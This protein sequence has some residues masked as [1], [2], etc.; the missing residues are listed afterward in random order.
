MPSSRLQR[1]TLV[2]L[3]GA[4]FAPAPLWARTGMPDLG[5]AAF[6]ARPAPLLMAQEDG[7]EYVD[8]PAYEEPV[9]DEPAYEEP[10]TEEPVYEE[11]AQE[12]PAYEE[13]A[14]SEE[15]AYEEPVQEEPTYEEPAQEEPV[16]EEA[17]PDEPAYEEPAPAE[18]PSFE[19]QQA[20]E[21]EAEEPAVEEEQQAEEP[22]ASEPV[23]DE[24]VEA[25]TATDEPQTEEP[26]GEDTA[27]E[28]DADDPGADAAAVDAAD[29][30]ALE[31]PA[32]ADAASEPD[33]NA[34]SEESASDES[35]AADDAA[36]ESAVEAEAGEPLIEDAPD[37]PEEAEA[38]LA[39]EGLAETAVSPDE[40]AADVAAAAEKAP[41]LDADGQIAEALPDG[42]DVAP[43]DVAPLFDS[44]KLDEA[45]QAEPDAASEAPP[46]TS[47]A[48]VQ[49]FALPQ[50]F[51]EERFAPGETLTAPPQFAQPSGDTTVIVNE[52]NTTINTTTINNTVIYES[53]DTLIVNDY[54][55]YEERLTAWGYDDF[56]YRRLDG[57]Y[58]SEAATNRDGSVVTTV[59]DAYGNI[60]ER[61]YY[62]RYG[63]TYVLSW[64]D[65]SADPITYEDVGR[66]LPPLR[67]R[68]PAR[69]YVLAYEDTDADEV[70]RFLSKPPVEQARRLYSIDEV[71][72]SA[73][74]RDTLP[75]VELGKLSFATGSARID[76][77]Q[78]QGLKGMAAAM[79]KQIR[80][81]PAETFLIE[82][83]TDAV[84][85]ARDNLVLSDRRARAVAEALTRYYGVPAQNLY[86]QG[87]GE[88]F[89]KVKTNGPSSVN[90]RVTV[91][92][93]TPLVTAVKGR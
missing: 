83:H 42:E 10:A 65:V 52:T 64:Y 8:E 79:L 72:R 38:V 66:R 71:K 77:R 75:R 29:A 91:R 59:Y 45:P 22:A 13:P 67:P 47:D 88:E 7:G 70:Y 15:P 26:A 76:K 92:R 82:G 37:A 32:Q 23:A 6:P 58:Y 87:Y 84:G 68:F 12:E 19:E 34:G 89:L 60:V 44:A 24:P 63:N 62:D 16:F 21:P 28:P 61:T 3:L 85:S 35:P 55:G 90:R 27:A 78:A 9:Q 46:P 56:A 39:D 43:Q 41:E 80:A 50:S 4:S 51:S 81:N 33:A 73:R 30:D 86:T 17:A 5:P 53:N 48:A 18:E 74:L 2:L 14:P 1:L 40:I 54:R 25:E 57:G 36:V 49:A 20:T 93:T 11:P 69:Y 31:E